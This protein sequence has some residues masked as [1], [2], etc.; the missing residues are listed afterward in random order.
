MSFDSRKNRIK[1]FLKQKKFINLNKINKNIFLFF[2]FL[3]SI[4]SNFE[5]YDIMKTE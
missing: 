4:F 2:D 5:N 3:Y 1:K